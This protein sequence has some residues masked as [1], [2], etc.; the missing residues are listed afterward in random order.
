[1]PGPDWNFSVYLRIY[2]REAAILMSNAG[3]ESA[4]SE[5]SCDYRYV[6]LCARS[7]YSWSILRPLPSIAW[8][9]ILS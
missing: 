7:G 9:A 4:A 5:L 2:D 3:R 1:M 6:I 8:V